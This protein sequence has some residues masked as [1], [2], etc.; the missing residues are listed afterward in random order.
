MDK[1]KSKLVIRLLLIALDQINDLFRFFFIKKLQ[2]IKS[3]PVFGK[4]AGTTDTLRIN[5]D[6]SSDLSIDA[7]AHPYH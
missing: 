3:L 6:T 7:S 5:A 1:M 2:W 4:P